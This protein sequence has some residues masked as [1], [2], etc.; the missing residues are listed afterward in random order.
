MRYE[1]RQAAG[2]VTDRICPGQARRNRKRRRRHNEQLADPTI[3]RK[4]IVPG[5]T[6]SEMRSKWNNAATIGSIRQRSSPPLY[7]L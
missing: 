1:V 5:W 4:Q 3:W 2:T 7:S 6:I